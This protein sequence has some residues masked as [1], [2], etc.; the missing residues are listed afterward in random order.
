MRISPAMADTY[1]SCFFLQAEPLRDNFN[2]ILE[3][4][5]GFSFK[6]TPRSPFDVVLK[7]S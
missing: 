5:F 4:I 1:L 7:V 6:G 3:G 2:V